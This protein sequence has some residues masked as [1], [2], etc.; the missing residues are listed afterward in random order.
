M[1]VEVGVD[2]GEEGEEGREGWEGEL[3]DFKRR[4]GIG[5]FEGNGIA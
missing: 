3:G 4:M 1:G 5:I 2:V